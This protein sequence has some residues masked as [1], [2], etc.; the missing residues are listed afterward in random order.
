MN[1]HV[2]LAAMTHSRA[3]WA[4]LFALL[5]LCIPL[6]KPLSGL[7]P[8]LAGTAL[9]GTVAL[10]V[11]AVLAPRAVSVWAAALAAAF[12]L[13]AGA[14]RLAEASPTPVLGLA[15]ETL[16]IALL[17]MLYLIAAAYVH[18]CPL[19]EPRMKLVLMVLAVWALAGVGTGLGRGLTLW[20]LV[21][22]RGSPFEG[23]GPYVDPTFIGVNAFLICV[24]ASA[25]FDL[26]AQLIARDWR[27]ASALL[28]LVVTLFA[29][30]RF[31]LERFDAR[32]L[33]SFRTVLRE[34]VSPRA[35]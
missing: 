15:P 4:L 28:A 5:A 14:A 11:A 18:V 20:D 3:G 32:S 21:M 7:D 16:L 23:V 22:R 12:T 13:M 17:G 33:P 29:G 8:Q 9:G 10:G 30:E 34:A 25:L 19:L 1:G 31:L 24:M 27:R 6:V 35:R 26:F 2:R